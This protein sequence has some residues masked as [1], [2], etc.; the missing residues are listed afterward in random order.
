M[1][2]ATAPTVVGSRWTVARRSGPRATHLCPGRI[3]TPSTGFNEARAGRLP[4]TRTHAWTRHRID[5][6]ERLADRLLTAGTLSPARATRP[7]ARTIA[8]R[9]PEDPVPLLRL[10]SAAGIA[11]A[12]LTARSQGAPVTEPW[13][14]DTRC[15]ALTVTEFKSLGDHRVVNELHID[16]AAFIAR[17]MARV[18]SL[19]TDGPNMIKWG[20]DAHLTELVFA[21]GA[22]P[23][24]IRVF[25]GMFQTP[26]TGF[27]EGQSETLKKLDADLEA[28]LHPAPGKTIPKVR[29]LA[30]KFKAFTLTFTGTAR[31]DGAPATVSG[32]TDSFEVTAPDG[33]EQTLRIRSGQRSPAPQPFAVG[34][35][36]FSIVT[37]QTRTGERLYPDHFQIAE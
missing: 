5:A 28:L 32:V 9:D 21:C 6:I 19:P 17:F 11:L 23:R 22:G 27:N 3:Q 25:E 33:G 1:T 31:F 36:H 16:D 18:A 34:K 8:A 2:R 24:T 12:L 20:P 37:Y 26:S 30:L 15:A 10:A 35:A 13:F 7:V 29:G 4:T 14:P